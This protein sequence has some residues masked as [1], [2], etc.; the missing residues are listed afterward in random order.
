MELSLT[1]SSKLTDQTVTITASDE[2]GG[3]ST[4]TFTVT[5]KVAVPNQQIY[6]K[7]SSFAGTSVDAALD[8]GKVLARPGGTAQTL[9]YANLVNGSRG[10]NGIVIDVAGL[11]DTSLTAADF[12]FKM[13]PQGAFDEAANPPSTW[14]AAPVPTAIVVTP[15]TATI[16]ARVR[17]EWPDNAIANRWLQVAVLA[18]AR[19]GL[20]AA[21]VS[22]VGHLQG[23]VNGQ[24]SNGRFRV[25]AADVT[26]VGAQ[27][28]ATVT[29]GSAFDIVMNGRITTADLTAVSS[30]IGLRELRVITIPVAGSGGHGTFGPGPSGPSLQSGT[31]GSGGSIDFAALASLG[32]AAAAAAADPPGNL[33]AEPRLADD[34]KRAG[35]INAKP[36]FGD[37]SSSQSGDAALSQVGKAGMHGPVSLIPVPSPGTRGILGRRPVPGGIGLNLEV[38]HGDLMSSASPA[39]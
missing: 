20:D 11:V 7:G 39:N 32:L 22:Y 28:G 6:H 33:D 19:T 27:I 26:P 13:S 31:S 3:T 2:D 17:L 12:S 1:P 9:S 14:A 10:L 25:T 23:E 5:A 8:P 24:V 18:N 30:Q 21:A 29:V 4:T 37:P 36:A 15:G 16:P 38:S 35:G 34:G